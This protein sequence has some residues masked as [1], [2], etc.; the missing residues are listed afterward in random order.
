MQAW[1]TAIKHS[2]SRKKVKKS[3]STPG[4]SL[5]HNQSVQQSLSAVQAGLACCLQ[6]IV[7][8]CSKCLDT[9]DAGVQLL[10][11]FDPSSNSEI[12]VLLGWENR[13]S[14]QHVLVDAATAQRQM[15]DTIRNKAEKLL[16]RLQ[17]AVWC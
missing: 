10:A 14:V 13:V 3:P 12:Q 5:L 17:Q 8:A 16:K 11:A 9:K 4:S 1:S 2:R 7:A 15:L 6:G